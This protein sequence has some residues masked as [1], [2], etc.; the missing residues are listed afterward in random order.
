MLPFDPNVALL[1]LY[2]NTHTHTH[3][4]THS[5][6]HSLTHS[7]ERWGFG[8]L[9]LSHQRLLDELELK[10]TTVNISFFVRNSAGETQPENAQ[11]HKK[12]V[13]SMDNMTVA[14][15]FQHACIPHNAYSL[16]CDSVP[17]RQ[18][19][20]FYLM[21]ASLVWLTRPTVYFYRCRTGQD[22]EQ[23][24]D[25]SVRERVLNRIHAED[26]T[27]WE[28][29]VAVARSI[30]AW[31]CP[32]TAG[33]TSLYD[34]HMLN[35]LNILP[36]RWF[37]CHIFG[38]SSSFWQGVVTPVYAS[39]FL[40]TNLDSVPAVCTSHTC[41]SASRSICCLQAAMFC[42]PCTINA[43]PSTCAQTVWQTYTLFRGSISSV[44]FWM[45]WHV[46]VV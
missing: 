39:T 43:M 33:R 21:Y 34:M 24:S 6:L 4:H 40:T 16:S 20:S 8:G 46:F 2:V 28:R 32:A 36:L 38:V 37:V 1:Y 5:L 22:F 7:L 41:S 35:P 17:N 27:K 23:G 9:A 14:L 10:H 31:F 25:A 13:V 19:W 29:A 44:I 11:T 3:T 30:N 12:N 26:V 18:F 15:G 42:W 45:T